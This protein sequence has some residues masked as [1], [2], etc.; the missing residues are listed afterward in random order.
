MVIKY[1]ISGKQPGVN[2]VIRC[3][4]THSQSVAPDHSQPIRGQYPGHLITLSQSEAEDTPAE[5]GCYPVITN[6][7][8]SHQPYPNY[9]FIPHQN[10]HSKPTSKLFVGNKILVERGVRVA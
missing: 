10:K 3:P 5:E 8:S 9:A 4:D 1:W 2:S 6:Q 7:Y